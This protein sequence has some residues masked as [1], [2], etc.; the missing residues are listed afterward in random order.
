MSASDF[1]VTAVDLASG[2]AAAASLSDGLLP[3]VRAIQEK[4]DATHGSA[5]VAQ[6]HAVFVAR[7][8][9]FMVAHFGPEDV[10]ELL[11]ATTRTLRAS[12]QKM[13]RELAARR[14]SLH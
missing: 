5:E 11:E 13:R 9:G 2:E 12:S 4:L 10:L 7:H 14:G 6:F 1:R 3:V 8:I